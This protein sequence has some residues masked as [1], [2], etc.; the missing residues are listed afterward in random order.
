M[1]QTYFTDAKQAL[2]PHYILMDY[3]RHGNPFSSSFYIFRKKI[4]DPLIITFPY[5]R[6]APS[7]KKVFYL[8]I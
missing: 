5:N 6:F 3:Y 2:L 4:D 7:I 1:L 8:I